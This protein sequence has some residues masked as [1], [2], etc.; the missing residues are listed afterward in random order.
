MFW[1]NVQI[2]K[3][4]GWMEISVGA[5]SWSFV[6]LINNNK[7]TPL[8]FGTLCQEFWLTPRTPGDQSFIKREIMAW[9]TFG[10]KWSTFGGR[11]LNRIAKINHS[12]D[13][14]L[15]TD[16]QDSHFNQHHHSP[17]ISGRW[18]IGRFKVVRIF[19][20]IK[21]RPIIGNA[22]KSQFFAVFPGIPMFLNFLWF[23]WMPAHRIGHRMEA[24]GIWP[25]IV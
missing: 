4:M 15:Q 9:S 5:S 17:T 2:Y 12:L 23:L 8:P 13:L 6:V 20:N 1:R 16:Y 21:R 24:D 25:E 10:K 18:Y 14:F 22:N 19:V 11:S 3:W 7:N